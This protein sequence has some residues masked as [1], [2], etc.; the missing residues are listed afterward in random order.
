MAPCSARPSPGPTDRGGAPT[1]PRRRSWSPTRPEGR[2]WAAPSRS[3]Y[4]VGR[5]S[6]A[7]PQCSSTPWSRRT[8][9]QSRSGATSASRSWAPC[10]KPS[11][12]PRTVGSAST[13]CTGTSDRA[14]VVA[15]VR[16][17]VVVASDA[18]K[19]SL[20]SLE[21]ADAVRSGLLDVAPDAVVTV[22]PVADGGEGT[23]TAAVAA[24][25][26]PVTT[27]VHGPTGAAVVATLAVRAATGDGR[28][29]A[30]PTVVVELADA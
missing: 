11:T 7:T 4:S 14:V 6:R 17:R 3:G 13:S 18:F 28:S 20:A 10:P 8:P 23:V 30:R 27:A 24:G 22:V 15:E 12:R 2:V 5:V 25:W 21:V 1:S 19:G 29:A 16:R 26:A 9:R